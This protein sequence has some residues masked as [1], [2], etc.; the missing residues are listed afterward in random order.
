[1]LLSIGQKDIARYSIR[2][3]RAIE[4]PHVCLL[5]LKKHHE[6]LTHYGID[7]VSSNNISWPLNPNVYV[8]VAESLT[9]GEMMGGVRI[10]IATPEFPLPIEDAVGC[11]DAKIAH[12]IK[13]YSEYG[14]IGETCGLWCSSYHKKK[15]STGQK[16][17]L[18]HR[19]TRAAVAVSNQFKLNTLMAIVGQP[20]L[21]SCRNI[22]FVESTALGDNGT[23]PY[24]KK[25]MVA[26]TL[27]VMNAKTLEQATPLDKKIIL[28][29]RQNPC[30]LK[31]EQTKTSEIEINYQLNLKF[32]D[33]NKY[34]NDKRFNQ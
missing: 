28:E 1:M 34:L 27:G 25:D 29:L 19:L 4:E 6:I 11:M 22:G 12:L 13:Q 15:G 14:G 10:H 7:M 2:A 30:Q 24:P 26:W 31:K 5:F 17:G 20:T 21:Q 3:L 16:I 9:T 33:K 8:L 18:G 23:F 32:E